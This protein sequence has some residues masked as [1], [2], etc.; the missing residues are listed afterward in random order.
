[1]AD[2]AQDSQ[3][4]CCSCGRYDNLPTPDR[5]RELHRIDDRVLCFE[6]FCR[7]GRTLRGVLGEER[8]LTLIE[9]WYG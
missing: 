6:C 8:V 7:H 2:T 9:N 5:K 1:M 4:A 3:E